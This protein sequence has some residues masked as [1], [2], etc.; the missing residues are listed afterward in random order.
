MLN[1]RRPI[2]GARPGTLILSPDARSTLVQYTIVSGEQVE[3]RV[4]ESVA[5]IPDSMDPEARIWID[6][7]GLGS[8]SALASLAGLYRISPLAME[9]LVNETQRPK[10]ELFEHQQ[11]IVAHGMTIDESRGLVP[12][13]LGIVFD[14]QHVITFHQNCDDLLRPIRMRLENPNARLRRYGTD[15]LVYAIIDALADGYYPVL[16]KL[17]ERLEVL[18]SRALDSPHPDVL[19]QVHNLKNQLLWLR[20]SVWPQ[21]DMVQSLLSD[22]SPF[23]SDPTERYLRD[24]LEHCTQIADMVD[25]YRESTGGL[26]NTYMSAVAHRS[27]EVMKVLTLMTSLFV[28]PTFLAGVYGMNFSSMPELELPGAY[29][30]IILLMTAMI[31]GMLMFFY[32]R[33]WLGSS[34]SIDAPSLGT[35]SKP[36]VEADAFVLSDEMTPSN[37]RAA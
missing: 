20:R 13:H 3:S 24:T 29:P 18:E 14:Q 16:E 22:D 26:A 21:R 37:K 35:E 33:G 25:M 10:S 8:P 23:F 15:Y 17:G 27:N 6:V 1:K 7:S 32:R 4:C 9:D 5:D 30:F 34:P 2:A 19:A 28:P 31:S 36:A 11:L 12:K